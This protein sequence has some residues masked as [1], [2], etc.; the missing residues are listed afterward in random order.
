MDL[1]ISCMQDKARRLLNHPP[2]MSVAMGTVC[3][4]TFV[5]SA[6][7]QWQ[8]LVVKQDSRSTP[9]TANPAPKVIDQTRIAKLFGVPAAPSQMT[10]LPLT[11]LGSFVSAKPDSFAALIQADGK[12][13]RRVIVRQE[14]FSG[15]R[16]AAVAT[17]YV[18]LERNDASEQ[19]SSPR[20]IEFAEAD[21]CT[22]YGT[23][24]TVEN[25]PLRY[26]HRHLQ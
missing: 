20:N 19:L 7:P 12:P 10:N 21:G 13:A 8:A 14:L 1:R 15:V 22:D 6:H 9:A 18:L 25:I 26:A 16:L 11:L 24:Y 3:L 17:D 5:R 2:T 23:S 4:L